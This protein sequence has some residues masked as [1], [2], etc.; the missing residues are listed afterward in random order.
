LKHLAVLGA[1][2][3]LGRSLVA[4]FEECG[5]LVSTFSFRPNDALAIE[6]LRT[7]LSEKNITAVVI[8]GASQNIGDDAGAIDELLQSNVFMPLAIA[9]LCKELSPA[10]RIIHFGSS[11]QLNIDGE[12]DPFNLYAATK[13]AAEETLRHYA[14]QGLEI[15][16][17]RLFDTYGSGDT[18]KKLINLIVQTIKN[19]ERLQTTEGIQEFGLMHIGDVLRAVEVVLDDEFWT[20]RTASLATFDL[21]PL[22]KQSV[23]EVI[24]LACDIEGVDPATLFDFGARPYRVGERMKLPSGSTL[25]GWEPRIRLEDGLRELLKS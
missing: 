14:N 25:P 13:T 24:E 1:N 21:A 9:L 15:V 3:F 16:S 20:N 19:G 10:T 6:S 18:R 2:G 7:G 22:V 17:L 11:W 23:R 12:R 5:W 8:A 4:H